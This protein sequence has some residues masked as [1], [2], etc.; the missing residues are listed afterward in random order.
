MTEWLQ[1]RGDH[2]HVS[3]KT[4]P[5]TGVNYKLPIKHEAVTKRFQNSGD[6]GQFLSNF[7]LFPCLEV[8]LGF[9]KL[10][11]LLIESLTICDVVIELQ[12]R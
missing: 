10:R 1:E 12:I 11:L 2:D 6:H 7:S 4:S 8:G 9:K 5:N 3:S